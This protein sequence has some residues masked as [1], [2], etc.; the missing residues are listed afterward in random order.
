MLNGLTQHT[1]KMLQHMCYKKRKLIW[2]IQKIIMVRYTQ[3]ENK[4]LEK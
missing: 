2:L 1:V 3:W 4:N